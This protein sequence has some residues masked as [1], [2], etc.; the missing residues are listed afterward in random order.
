MT[1]HDKITN[2][3][4]DTQA[5]NI[6]KML[7][8]M[9]RN[10]YFTCSC[11][12]HNHW[13]GGSSQHMLAVYLIAK[14]LRDQRAHEPAVA[15]YAT[16]E[17]LAIVC[18]LHDLCD[19]RVQV[20][21][22]NHKEVHGHGK[23]SYWIM[24]N[25][26]VG[27]D[28]ER[29]VVCNHMHSPMERPCRSSNPDEVD[30]YNTL[31]SFVHSAD[32]KAA[33]CAWNST[34]FKEGRTQHTGV[35]SSP[36]YLMAMAI[37]R[38]TQS[39]QNEM[40][41]DEHY[42]LRKFRTF[43]DVRDVRLLDR[44]EARDLINGKKRVSIG[45]NSDIITAAH[46]YATKSGERLCFV[47]AADATIPQDRE[48]RLKR[49]SKEEQSLL[50]CSSLMYPFYNYELCTE[51]GTKRHRYEFT[52]KDEVKRLYRDCAERNGALYLDG[53]RIIRDGESRGFPF[54]ETWRADIMLVLGGEFR[55]FVISRNQS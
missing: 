49:R 21:D 40:Y 38:T 24:K 53:I 34:R 5:A 17:K 33:G 55:T 43:Y 14:E 4:K 41:V 28:V 20:Y 29:W 54:V 46:E 47:M 36:G 13:T 52:M 12:S 18:L 10:G 48:T 6:D 9:E 27:T 26:N 30:E 23:K 42:E 50:I 16:D 3:L 22:N 31:L 35:T 11:S 45:N 44:A 7:S 37:D 25:L 51:K 2:A 32:H 8:Y 39:V 19:M 15:K 1:L